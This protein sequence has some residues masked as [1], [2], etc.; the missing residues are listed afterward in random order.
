MTGKYWKDVEGYIDAVLSGEKS[1]G[2]DITLACQRFK[3]GL[4]NPDW[5]FK[6]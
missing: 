3:D 4:N 6:F 5:E 2:E 1:A